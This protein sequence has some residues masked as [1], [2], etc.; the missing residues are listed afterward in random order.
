MRDDA[1]N[2]AP[3][4]GRNA[5]AADWMRRRYLRIRL[6]FWF[7][8]LLIPS[9]CVALAVLM[10]A[11]K[12][13]QPSEL[14]TGFLCTLFLAPVIGLIGVGVL[15]KR[16]LRARRAAR[17]AEQAERM[18]LSYAH[19]PEFEDF[20]W[21]QLLFMFRKAVKKPKANNL[22]A[23]DF[24]GAAVTILDYIYTVGA[25]DSDDGSALGVTLAVLESIAIG[26]PS[27]RQRDFRQTLI[28]CRRAV[29][30]V[31]DFLLTPK[32]WR[33]RLAALFGGRSLEVPGAAAFNRTFVLR[34]PEPDEVLV[35]M[36]P[37]VIEFLT[38]VKDWT[39]EVQAGT[40]AV[41]RFCKHLPPAEYPDFMR[42]VLRLAALLRG[43]GGPELA[44]GERPP[45]SEGIIPGDPGQE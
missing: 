5:A 22:V 45:S 15:L 19:R 10:S 42:L 36:T 38:G 37:E 21:L 31:P 44:P 35:C 41:Q 25:P 17:V 2:A 39:V 23:G 4:P 12:P 32:G 7:C 11:P 29:P 3:T 34:S 33:D 43:A 14:M 26:P 9:G 18:G 24:D 16:G 20:A 8:V 28:A 40:L 1:D 27:Q 30:D 13:Q 6:A